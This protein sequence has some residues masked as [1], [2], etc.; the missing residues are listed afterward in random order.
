MMSLKAVSGTEAMVVSPHHLASAAGAG[1]LMKGGNAFDAAVA[2]SAC[3]AVVYPHMTGLGGDAFW[4]VYHRGDGAVRVYNASGRSGHLATRERFAGQTA[5][6]SQGPH[7]AITVPGMVD[8]WE[9]LLREYG[10]KTLAEVL[11]PSIRY[12]VNGIPVASH[13]HGAL[14]ERA[15]MLSMYSGTARV[16]LPG[17]KIPQ[18]GAKL[19]QRQLGESLQKLA[20]GGKEVFYKG[21]LAR[22]MTWD[23]QAQGGLLTMED[24]AAHSGEWTV[25]VTGSY[26]GYEIC[27]AP[28]NSQGFTGILALH[29]LEHAD[30]NAVPY[31]SYEYYHLLVE[32][33][34]T[35]FRDRDRFLT[36]PAFHSVPLDRLLSKEYGLSRFADIDM[37]RAA[38]QKA[39][40]MG[41]DSV[42][43]AVTD[44]E[45]NAV[46]FMASLYSEF[47]S[48]VTAGNTGILLQS[49]GA[50]FSLDPQHPNVLE[51][52]K[53]CFH[54]LM[55][56]MALRNGKP[57]VL[58]G[59]Q[60]GDAQSQNQTAILTR[61]IDFGMDPQE[62]INEPRWVWGKTRGD[63]GAELK[64]EKRITG[65]AV[66]KLR[67][68]GHQVKI[69][70]PV[71]GHMGHAH[72]IRF[73]DNG[74]LAGGTDPRSDG[75][76]IGW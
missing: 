12:A 67:K 59:T 14:S 35:S 2:I 47:G 55:P 53:R 41:E 7:S 51:P 63:S 42:Y 36:D 34:K 73:L 25:P 1:I 70:K 57:A 71:D 75:S 17:G 69:V 28:P 50:Q 21:E 54:S 6:P 10:T 52:G 33:A 30:M 23:L 60:G 39:A 62:A 45:G 18:T 26:R 13:L 16:Y 74:C 48:L 4:L 37:N 66:D 24:L 56:A 65:E 20:A 40:A 8:S 46:S 15:L 29:I 3:L 64:L 61:M 5:I 76:V 43:A 22:A 68:A 11:E 27:Q 58:Y 9:A 32:A 44:K 72:A 19:V 31:G 38:D 49:Q